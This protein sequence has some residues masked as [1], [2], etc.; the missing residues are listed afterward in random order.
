MEMEVDWNMFLK[1]WRMINGRGM[2]QGQ[3]MAACKPIWDNEV[4]QQKF[5]SKYI[6]KDADIP[7]SQPINASNNES[8][9]PSERSGPISPSK[10]ICSSKPVAPSSNSKAPTANGKVKDLKYYKRKAAYEKFRAEY[11]C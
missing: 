8:N 7:N 10:P 11:G 4:E 1:T 2:T 5:I 3:A 9:N 6:N